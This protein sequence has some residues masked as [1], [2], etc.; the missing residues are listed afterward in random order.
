MV[1][2][3]PEPHAVLTVLCIHFFSSKTRPEQV[4]KVPKKLKCTGAVTSRA[5][6]FVLNYRQK[7]HARNCVIFEYF[8]DQY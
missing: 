5:Q 3:V 4:P 7:C 2:G 1:P 6:E 8:W